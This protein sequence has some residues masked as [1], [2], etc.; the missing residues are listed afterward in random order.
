[1]KIQATNLAANLFYRRMNT[2]NLEISYEVEL[3]IYTQL[4]WGSRFCN[5]PPDKPRTKSPGSP[6]CLCCWRTGDWATQRMLLPASLPAS[7]PRC[8]G[9]ELAGV[10][11]S[12]SRIQISKLVWL[13][14]TC[15]HSLKSHPKKESSQKP[16]RSFSLPWWTCRSQQKGEKVQGNLD[17]T[18]NLQRMWKDSQENM[19]RCSIS[20]Q[21]MAVG[22]C[23]GRVQ[24]FFSN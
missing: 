4:D 10:L 17:Y 11:V 2:K 12:S 9:E 14:A 23:R 3:L 1:M 22:N 21:Y 13:L 6:S 19:Y 20:V 18:Q 5:K 15:C 24:F 7:L 8:W 16:K